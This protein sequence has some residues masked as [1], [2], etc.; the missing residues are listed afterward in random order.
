MLP[1]RIGRYHIKR[2]IAS[3]GMGTVYEAAQDNPRR[4]VAVKVMKQGIASKS[5]LRRFGYEAQV[6]YSVSPKKERIDDQ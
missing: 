1:D 5:A 4:V 6:D 3:G 2:A